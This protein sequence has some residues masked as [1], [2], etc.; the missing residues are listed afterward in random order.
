MLELG[1]RKERGRF[2]VKRNDWRAQSRG[3]DAFR[4]GKLAPSSRPWSSMSNCM[5]NNTAPAV[6]QGGLCG[7]LVVHVTRRGRRWFSAV[8]MPEP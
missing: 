6:C 5:D 1:R 3:R 8:R 2:R 7:A 4:R